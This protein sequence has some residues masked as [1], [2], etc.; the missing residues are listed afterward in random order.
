MSSASTSV[1]VAKTEVEAGYL[2][3]GEVEGSEA[4]YLVC[5][6]THIVSVA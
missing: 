5:I 1:E 2:E 4:E 6:S 3:S